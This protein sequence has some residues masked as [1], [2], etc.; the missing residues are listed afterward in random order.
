MNEQKICRSPNAIR[1][2]CDFIHGHFSGDSRQARKK[3]LQ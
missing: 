2:R 1:S 3:P